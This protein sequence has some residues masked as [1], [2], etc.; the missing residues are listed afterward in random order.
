M[1]I[2]SPENQEEIR[3][4]LNVF[5]ANNPMSILDYSR[6]AGV[7]Y[8]TVRKFA[9]GVD[10]LRVEPLFKMDKFMKDYEK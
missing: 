3:K 8:N 6:G 9:R 1:K 7:G 4:A 5:M 2:K 10:L